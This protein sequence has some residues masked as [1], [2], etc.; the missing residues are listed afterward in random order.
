M[1]FGVLAAYCI[2]RAAFAVLRVHA[3]SVAMRAAGIQPQAKPQVA[4]LT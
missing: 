2:C 1:A 4:R 3:H